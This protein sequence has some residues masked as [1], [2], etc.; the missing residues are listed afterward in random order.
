MTSKYAAA[1][2]LIKNFITNNMNDE[3]ID[4]NTPWLLYCRKVE[5]L[6]ANDPDVIVSYNNNEPKVALY[7][8]TIDKAKALSKILPKEKIFDNVTLKIDVIA[9]DFDKASTAD[10]VR[11]AFKGNDILDKVFS[12]TDPTGND[13]TYASFK[14]RACQYLAD[15]ISDPYGNETMLAADIA[16]DVFGD[17]LKGVFICTESISTY[18]GIN[19]SD[20]KEEHHACGSCDKDCCDK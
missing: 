1:A 13:R 11:K 9:P 4:L 3:K 12:A 19:W 7:V 6:F 20:T 17:R 8:S 5:C 16:K 15:D 14:A 2:E 18:N 10:L